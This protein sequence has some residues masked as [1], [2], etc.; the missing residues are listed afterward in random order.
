MAGNFFF[1]SRAFEK[2]K[3]NTYGL[4]STQNKSFSLCKTKQQMD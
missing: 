1:V 2:E 4:K 3:K